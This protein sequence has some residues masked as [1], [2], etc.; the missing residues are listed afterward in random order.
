[1]YGHLDALAA[2]SLSEASLVLTETKLFGCWCH[3]HGSNSPNVI[4]LLDI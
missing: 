1:M 4:G 3:F 2:Q